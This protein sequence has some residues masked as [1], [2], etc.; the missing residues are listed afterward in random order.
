MHPTMLTQTPTRGLKLW[1]PQRKQVKCTVRKHLN[2]RWQFAAGIVRPGGQMPSLHVSSPTWAQSSASSH[3]TW[4]KK[5]KSSWKPDFLDMTTPKLQ[6]SQRAVMGF[7]CVDKWQGRMHTYTNYAEQA[8]P[9]TK[10]HSCKIKEIL[11]NLQ[12][13]STLL[14]LW[15]RL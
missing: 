1:S 12:I 7:N 15:V 5:K 11:L 8:S 6:G 2:W 10:S 3:D 9:M 13:L 4:E 14:S